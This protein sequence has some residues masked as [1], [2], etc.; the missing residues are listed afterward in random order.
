MFYRL[1][2]PVMK[3]YERNIGLAEK[4]DEPYATHVPVLV[5]VAAA[6]KPETIIEFGSGCFSTLSL[7]D[8]T[9]FPSIRRV[10][11]YENNHEWLD[12]VRKKLTSTSRINLHFVEGDMYKAV[13]AAQPSAAGMIFVDD[14]PT[15]QARVPTVVEVARFCGSQPVVILH[16]NDLWRLRLATRNFE[17]RISINTFNPQCCVMWHGHAERLPKL[18]RVGKI[19]R[20]CGTNIPLTDIRTWA[21]VF[22]REL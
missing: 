12:Q 19:I 10:D 17:H 18:Q 15:A 16:D 9:A 1:L 7:L 3:L 22:S 5:G 21:E 14:S 2:W 11:S 13:R 4:S 8:E 20:E 6:C